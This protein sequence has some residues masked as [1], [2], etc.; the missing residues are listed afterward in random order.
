MKK[1]TA[2]LLLLTF[3]FIALICIGIFV[4]AIV[5]LMQGTTP[6]LFHAKRVALVRVE[7]LIYDAKG[8]VDQIKEYQE[9]DTIKSII[10]R[11][12]SPGGAVS[13]SQELHNAILHARTVHGKIVVASFGDVAAS[14]GY[15]V[16]CGADQI[17]SS[18]G[19]LTGSIGVYAKFLEA[20]DLMEKIGIGYETVKAGKYK[21]FGS[22]DR[23]LTEEERAMMQGVIDDTYTQFVE[24][25]MEGRKKSLT[26]L[27]KEWKPQ[28]G[29]PAYPFSPEVISAITAY[30][31]KL[32]T[33][34]KEDSDAPHRES[35]DSVKSATDSDPAASSKIISKIDE[36][37]PEQ[38]VLFTLVKSLAEGKVYTGRQ[39]KEIALVDRLGTLQDAIDLAAK[40][41]GIEGKPTVVEKKK[42]EIGWLDLFSE[43][44]AMLMDRKVYS[45]IQYRFPY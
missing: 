18:P 42:R 30:Q 39:A 34:T 19:C 35:S 25:V 14:G 21:D 43:G 2:I 44:A 23:K 3:F 24:A 38:A 37:I 6:N 16:A 28:G 4:T 11:V 10:L 41:A 13:P 31:E 1:S 7:G 40:L 27:L 32:K 33:Q 45:P 29:A 9:D 22:M 26:K 17:V 5:F 12:D 36:V 15:Y 8:W 20:K